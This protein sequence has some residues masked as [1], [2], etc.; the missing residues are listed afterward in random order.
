ML[1]RV[2][3][4][5]LGDLEAAMPGLL[6]QKLGHIFQLAQKQTTFAA[7][8]YVN[9]LSTVVKNACAAVRLQAHERWRA[10]FLKHLP[11][12]LV[13]SHRLNVASLLSTHDEPL[14]VGWAVLLGRFVR[15]C[16]SLSLCVCVSVCLCVCL[17][18]CLSVSLCLSPSLPPL[19]LSFC[20]CHPLQLTQARPGLPAITTTPFDALTSTPHASAAQPFFFP[21]EMIDSPVSF[22]LLVRPPGKSTL[23]P[24]AASAA[25]MAAASA[26]VSALSTGRQ[27]RHS[28][29][30]SKQ[31]TA[32]SSRYSDDN[33]SVSDEHTDE[34]SDPLQLLATAPAIEVCLVVLVNVHVCL[35]VLVCAC[36][37][38]C[39]CVSMCVCVWSF[40]VVFTYRPLFPTLSSSPP[41]LHL[42]PPPPC[43][44]RSTHAKRLCSAA[45]RLLPLPLRMQTRPRSHTFST[46][47][48]PWWHR[49]TSRTRCSM[50]PQSGLR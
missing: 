16:F 38:A 32:G 48:P 50:W 11:T 15:P 17:F 25:T 4:Y 24:S 8:A 5:C 40:L 39:V 3:C 12:Q 9:L 47:S 33:S 6:C 45:W 27:S 2:A 1:R 30:R 43:G 28:N 22:A 46:R 13:A 41:R 10:P 18:V 31:S 7:Q 37:C 14:T 44:S 26:S 36:V 49:H 23:Q 20:L 35:C 29:S 21:T 19:S 42:P 34:Q